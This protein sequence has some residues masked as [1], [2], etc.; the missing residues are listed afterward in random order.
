[1]STGEGVGV[2][3]HTG[4]PGGDAE[5][6]ALPSHVLRLQ[7]ACAAT[8]E[9]RAQQLSPVSATGAGKMLEACRVLH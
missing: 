6:E 9:R 4:Q 2:G 7:D 5:L 3:A 1:V 8:Q